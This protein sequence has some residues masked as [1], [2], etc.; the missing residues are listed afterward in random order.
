M[1]FCREK[2]NVVNH[3][4]LVKSDNR[5][6]NLEWVS[7]SEDLLHAH[8]NGAFDKRNQK[9]TLPIETAKQIASALGVRVDSLYRFRKA[10]S[11]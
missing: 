11:K 1:A 8:L 3:K 6:A 10:Q 7:K 4:N 5:A 9:I 2:K